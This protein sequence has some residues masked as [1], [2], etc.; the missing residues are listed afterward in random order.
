R[1]FAG[2]TDLVLLRLDPTRLGAPVKWEPGAPSDDPDMR[3]PHLY[4]PLPVAAV[5]AVEEYR[6]GP[7]GRFPRLPDAVAPGRPPPVADLP[8]EHRGLHAGTQPEFGQHPRDV[9]FHRRLTDEQVCG[10]FGVGQARAQT[11]EHLA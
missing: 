2:R 8:G 3:F 6:A 11:V 4:A 9:S 10:D 1:L 7:G 5:I